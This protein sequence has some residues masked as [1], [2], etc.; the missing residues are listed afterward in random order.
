LVDINLAGISAYP[1][2]DKLA[3]RGI[4]V[5]I[6]SGYDKRPTISGYPPGVEGIHR[7]A[8]GAGTVFALCELPLAT[9]RVSCA[10]PRTK[11]PAVGSKTGRM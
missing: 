7:E 6:H 5:V 4:P 1:L 9:R 10:K 8:P 2:I 3:L 11:R